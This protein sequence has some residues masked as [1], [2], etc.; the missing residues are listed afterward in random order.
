MRLW[1][2][3]LRVGVCCLPSGRTT[4]RWGTVVFMSPAMDGAL[5]TLVSQCWSTWLR[6]TFGREPL[7]YLLTASIWCNPIDCWCPDVA[8][9]GLPLLY[10]TN[11]WTGVCT[12]RSLF[13]QRD[14]GLWMPFLKTNL[15]D[16]M[17]SL[18][19][20]KNKNK[21]NASFGTARREGKNQVKRAERGIG[22]MSSR[23]TS[24]T[25]LKMTDCTS[26]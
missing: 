7:R 17:F 18:A 23:F 9:T 22:E 14:L 12:E 11:W 15:F 2:S 6:L 8:V 26:V 4:N 19:K 20:Y 21:H 1:R 16:S 24:S 13:S 5:N 3:E 25:F 10:L